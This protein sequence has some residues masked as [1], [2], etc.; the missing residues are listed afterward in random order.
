MTYGARISRIVVCLT[1]SEGYA[2]IMSRLETFIDEVEISIVDSVDSLDGGA[3]ARLYAEVLDAEQRL[4][5]LRDALTL[6]AA[7]RPS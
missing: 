5:A 6:L 7:G 1:R 4:D 3:A 2:P